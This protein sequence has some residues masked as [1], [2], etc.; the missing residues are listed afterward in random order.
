MQRRAARRASRSR[1]PALPSARTSRSR[2][3]WASPRCCTSRRR[4]ASSSTSASSGASSSSVSGPRTAARPGTPMP[5]PRTPTPTPRHRRRSREH[6]R[7][8]RG[9]APATAETSTQSPAAP[10][11]A[12]DSGFDGLDFANWGAGHPPDTNGDVGPTYY[13]QTI[14]S[15]IG[16]FDK[17]TGT[18][19]RRVHVQRLHEP[20]A[21]SGTSATPTTSA[22]PSSSTTATR[23]AGSSPTSRSRSTGAATS[24][25]RPPTS[26]SPSRRPATRSTAAGTSIRSWTPG[27]LGD[28]PKFGVWPNGIYMSANMFGYAAGASYIS[29][30][31]WALDKQQMYAG[32][33]T[34]QVVD[35]SG[36]VERLYAPPGQLT[37]PGRLPRRRARPSTSSPRSSS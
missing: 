27:G 4:A 8:K 37:A 9:A 35:F 22:T 11:P 33:P 5:T 12:P 24:I 21:S 13:I 10:A 15:S 30:H 7:R 28:Y 16:I 36:T 32:A 25:R 23:T 6:R 31:V 19:G 1:R 26:A 3:G 34:V 20:G 17:S 18:P 2:P 29:P 14:N